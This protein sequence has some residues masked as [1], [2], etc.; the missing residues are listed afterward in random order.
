MA[1]D[2]RGATRSKPNCMMCPAG[3][4]CFTGGGTTAELGVWND[5]VQT[6][7]PVFPGT[8][9]LFAE[10][11]TV[12]NVYLVRAG[13]LKTFTVDEDGNERIR[14]FHLPGDVIGLDSLAHDGYASSAAA[15]EPSQ[16]CVIPRARIAPLSGQA[17][18]L[19]LRLLHRSSRDLSVALALSGDY[20]AEQRVAGFLM[21]MRERTGAERKLR[22]PMTRRDIGNFLRMATETVC[23]VITR[24]ERQGV[25]SSHDR[26]IE[27][28]D[29]PQLTV[30]GEP[31]GLA[32]PSNRISLAA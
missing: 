22:L 16:V 7:M 28:I 23:R 8:G 13:C 21:M 6:H 20:T 18:G 17:P 30:L 11:D 19:L 12:E 14:A 25:L 27:I 9:N 26:S 29:L 3:T 10:G 31:V 32:E 24:L 2:T 4:R 1:F 15:I 5:A